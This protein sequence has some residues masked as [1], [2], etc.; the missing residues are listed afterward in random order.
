MSSCCTSTA[1]T[2]TIAA[3]VN[4]A[5]TS[6]TS[7]ATA[8]ASTAPAKGRNAAKNVMTATGTASA[9]P[10]IHTVDP[11]MMPSITPRVAEPRR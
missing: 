9:P 2:S 5:D 8:P 11:M 7:T 3:G 10:T 4:P 6:V 1:T